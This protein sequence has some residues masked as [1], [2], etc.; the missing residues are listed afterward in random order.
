MTPLAEAQGDQSQQRLEV[1]LT[2]G[3][4]PAVSWNVILNNLQGE[5]G[6]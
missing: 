1:P 4:L 2:P 3:G 6:K 5:N